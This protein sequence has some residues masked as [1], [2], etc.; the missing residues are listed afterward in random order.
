VSTDIRLPEPVAAPASQGTIVEQ[1]RAVAEVAA[2]V[3]VAQDFP[4]DEQA[5]LQQ[6]RATCSRTAVAER[7][8]YEVPNRGAGLSIHAARELARI[9]GNIDYG[10]RELSR[11]DE[12]GMSE[13]QAWAWD[14]QTNVRSTRSFLVPHQKMKGGRRLKLDDL[15]DIYL[16]NQNIGARAVRECILSTLPG[17]FVSEADAVLKKTLRDGEGQS[18]QERITAAIAKFSELDITQAQLEE[19]IGRPVDAWQPKDLVTLTRIYSTISIDGIPATEFFP[20]KA[21]TV[22]EADPLERTPEEQQEDQS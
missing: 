1:S 3:R 4:R 10:V 11:D 2:A 13:M 19:R 17:W 21:I 6:M 16:N 15:S 20:E 18:P 12:A 22:P 5:A 9:W 8:F 7:A 14:Q